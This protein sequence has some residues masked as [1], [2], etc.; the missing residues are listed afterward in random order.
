[1]SAEIVL[2]Q[3]GGAGGV[4]GE[5]VEDVEVGAGVVAEVAAEV[6]AEV[7]AAAAAAFAAAAAADAAATAATAAAFVLSCL[8]WYSCFCGRALF[9][10]DFGAGAVLP[11]AIVETEAIFWADALVVPVHSRGIVA[12]VDE[13]D[14]FE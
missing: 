9:H 1:M 6:A 11:R 3:G 12:V 13:G 14:D 8:W 10:L 7:T 5:D 2:L 4:G